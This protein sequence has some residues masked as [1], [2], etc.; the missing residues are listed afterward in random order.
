MSVVNQINLKLVILG[1]GGVGKTSLVYSMIDKEIPERYMP[2]IGS[3]IIKQD[4]PINGTEFFVRINAW[5]IGG[6]RSFNPLNPVFFSNNDAAFL[7]FDLS[8]PKE[9]IKNLQDV[10]LRKLQENSNECLT[11]IVGNKLDLIENKGELKTILQKL[12]LPE[13]PILLISA[14]TRNFVDKAFDLLVYS[15]LERT[16]NDSEDIQLSGLASKFL[17][18]IGKSEE[19]LKSALINLED[20][21]T[22]SI[23]KLNTPDIVRKVVE[24]IE[25]PGPKPSV[26]LDKLENI[27]NIKMKI[28]ESFN[29]NLKSLEELVENLKKTPIEKLVVSVDKVLEQMKYYQ[30]DFRQKLER[31]FNIE[32]E[33]DEF[34]KFMFGS[35]EEKRS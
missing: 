5:D 9:T 7:M 25:V 35:K 20:I 11:F 24:P 23:Q 16:E 18:S 31:Y 15:Y 17:Q 29:L 6:Q 33:D 14:K 12:K 32:K 21:E 1:D 4:F 2:T 27:E 26:I 8:N 22:L 13:L 3:N 19:Q 30:D 28:Q 34:H 10:Y